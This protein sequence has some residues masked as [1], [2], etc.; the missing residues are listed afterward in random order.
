MLAAWRSGAAGLAFAMMAGMAVSGC[1]G[2][3]KTPPPEVVPQEAFCSSIDYTVI[4]EKL[5]GLLVPHG[6]SAERVDDFKL[7][8]RHSTYDGKLG[9]VAI[10]VTIIHFQSPELAEAEAKGRAGAQASPDPS[11]TSYSSVA[12]DGKVIAGVRRARYLAEV[13][14]IPTGRPGDPMLPGIA[15]DMADRVIASLTP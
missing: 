13:R 15:R 10:D 6:P 11:G 2:T 7:I 5:G 4:A 8:C 3:T 12:N 14:L 1:A 9:N